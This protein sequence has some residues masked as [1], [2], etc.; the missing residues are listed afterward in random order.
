[1]QTIFKLDLNLLRSFDALLGERNVTRAAERPGLTEPAMSGILVRLRESLGDALF[2]RAQRGIMPTA[3]VLELGDPVRQVLA[4]ID[5]LLHL[6][7]FDPAASHAT[8][9]IAATD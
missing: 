9:T 3:R 1:M 8:I 7:Q 2:V 6:P 5:A 4:D